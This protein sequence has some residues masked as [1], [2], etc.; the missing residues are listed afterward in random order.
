MKVST[1]VHLSRSVTLDGQAVCQ[2][3]VKDDDE[4]RRHRMK[5]RKDHRDCQHLRREMT[6][7]SGRK[8]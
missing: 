5:D 1:T 2:Q 3:G 6:E 8:D 7:L 4:I